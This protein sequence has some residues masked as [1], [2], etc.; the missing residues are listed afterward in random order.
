MWSFLEENCADVVD[1]T[2][3]TVNLTSILTMN[4]PLP[5]IPAVID[6][7]TKGNLQDNHI[8]LITQFIEQ[9]MNYNPNSLWATIIDKLVNTPE[10]I[11]ELAQKKYKSIE[12]ILSC[13]NYLVEQLGP[14]KILQ[15]NVMILSKVYTKNLEYI[16][17]NLLK[18]GGYELEIHYEGEET[19][20]INVTDS[21]ANIYFHRSKAKYV[22]IIIFNQATFFYCGGFYQKF[23]QPV[24]QFFHSD[25]IETL[26]EDSLTVKYQLQAEQDAV[27]FVSSFNNDDRSWPVLNKTMND[28]NGQITCQF[29]YGNYF[30]II[31]KTNVTEELQSIMSK[32]LSIEDSL[33]RIN[34]LLRKFF[35]FFEPL[36][37]NYVT[38][39]VGNIEI[40]KNK[41]T[42]T[43]YFN[44][45]NELLNIDLLVLKEAE[46]TYESGSKLLLYTEKIISQ[47]TE[48]EA[49]SLNNLYLS[50]LNHE[51]NLKVEDCDE[52][53]CKVIF[54]DG[55]NNDCKTSEIC[56]IWPPGKVKPASL[57]II[58]KNKLKFFD[59]FSKSTKLVG[60]FHGES[61]R[62][63]FS[64]VVF[65]WS[66][67][68]ESVD[69]KCKLS[70]KNTDNFIWEETN[71]RNL[72]DSLIC[73]I[74]SG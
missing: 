64:D 61:K 42:L 10:D 69:T 53:T 54:F 8:D 18:F 41:K 45:L 49:I 1:K 28:N 55:H 26:H 29:P 74:D 5:H 71:P 24:M 7:I 15:P 33:E 66:K 14:T 36:D 25:N 60:L 43:L 47:F 56:I 50:H 48:K 38:N 32:K 68:N 40:A 59:N 21:R 72:N 35:S 37:I 62:Q 22:T 67:R 11:L 34:E 58:F 30:G 44:I 65:T 17:W 9:L 3:I 23:S 70:I 19:I 2:N 52:R 12:R 13:M 57:I 4:N 20:E 6:I 46:K 31:E 51:A 63:E 39:I 16:S 27:C 73:T